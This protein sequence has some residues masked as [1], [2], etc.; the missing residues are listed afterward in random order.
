[1]KRNVELRL[2]ELVLHDF[3]PGNRHRVGEAAERELSR[4]FAEH[5]VPPLLAHGEAVPRIDAGTLKISTGAK[6]DVVGAQVARALYGR[7]MG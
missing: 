5:G 1:M 4:L 6:A 3:A 7:M 2:K